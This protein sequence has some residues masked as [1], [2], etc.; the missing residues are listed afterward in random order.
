[1]MKFKAAIVSLAMF[2][3]VAHAGE[4]FFSVDVQPGPYMVYGVKGETQPRNN[5]ACYAEVNWRD[6]SKLQLVR[7]LDD[8]ELYIWFQNNSWSIKDQPGTYRLRINFEKN[9]T[10][11]RGLD[12]EYRLL[13]KNSI[14]IRNI[15]KEL[16]LP[17]FS[18]GA[19]MTIVMP[20]TISNAEVSLE[21]ST[22]ALNEIAN[23]VD[24]SQGMNLWPD[25]QPN[26]GSDNRAFDRI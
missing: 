15:K 3:T 16:F 5:P 10:V 7:D 19:K 26:G 25:G 23:C 9:G 1:M 13:S 17:L 21:G 2:A 20:G 4:N 24:R 11:L 8:G 14:A 12:F 6:G 18:S 22:R